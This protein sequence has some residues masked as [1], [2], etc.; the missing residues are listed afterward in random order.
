MSHNLASDLFGANVVIA[1]K[2]AWHNVGQVFQDSPDLV[3]G[4]SRAR[5]NYKLSLLPSYFQ[6]EGKYYEV[7][8]SRQ[9]V[10][11]PLMTK[12]GLS[13][14][15]PKSLGEVSKDYKILQNSEI[16]EIFN[17]LSKKWP[18]ES[19]GALGDGEK[20]F[21]T[22]AAGEIEINHQLVNQ[23]FIGTDD[24]K[25][26]EK[27]KFVYA[28]L[29]VV[30][31]NTL[32]QAISSAT[33]T[34]NIR[35]TAGNKATLEKVAGLAERMQNGVDHTN[36]IF[37]EM[38]KVHFSLDDFKELLKYELYPEPVQKDN[39]LEAGI[40]ITKEISAMKLHQEA[41]VEVMARYND[42]HPENANTRWAGLMAVSEYEQHIRQG[43]GAGNY[44]N[45]LFGAR[46]Q[47]VKSAFSALA[48]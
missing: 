2:P 12:L 26:E 10:K 46:S 18:V 15:E 31:Q 11:E 5:I 39:V 4:F 38:G 16:A 14:P 36:E 19:A 37:S 32:L 33:F 21:F 43:R 7:K 44:S 17:P 23:Y 9:I 27:T 30:C 28:P 29:V 20:I 34:I 1:R 25:G 24:K 48:K 47:I 6:Y 41:C 3:E 45:Q 42:E 8:E 13:D 40:D 35:H 22:L